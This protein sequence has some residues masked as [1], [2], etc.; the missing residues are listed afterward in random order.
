MMLNGV[1][2][3]AERFASGFTF[4]PI[5]S[6]KIEELALTLIIES[7]SVIRLRMNVVIFS[8]IIHLGIPQPFAIPGVQSLA[9][10]I[11]DSAC[12]LTISRCTGCPALETRSSSLLSKD[13][14]GRKWP[15]DPGLRTRS[16]RPR[17]KAMGY[18]LLFFKDGPEAVALVKPG[19]KIR[20]H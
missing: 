9:L 16:K 4:Q 3:E 14:L 2:G 17:L 1:K 11:T 5:G 20:C 12:T 13:D 8:D 6:V 10:E 15:G 19:A 18:V 7:E